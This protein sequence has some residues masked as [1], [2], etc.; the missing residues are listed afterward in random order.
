MDTMRVNQHHITD[1][2]ALSINGT[3]VTVTA[4]D[5]NNAVG[6]PLLMDTGAPSVTPAFVGQMYYKTDATVALYIAI[7]TT[8][9]S[10]W[11]QVA[12]T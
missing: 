11:D 1:V 5:I 7:G 6:A 3:S 8:N 10:D 2:K 12:L 4:D 9:S